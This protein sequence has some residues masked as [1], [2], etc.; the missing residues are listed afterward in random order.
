MILAIFGAVAF[1][2]SVVLVAWMTA[3]YIET[4]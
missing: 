3:K 1:H 2:L 4:R